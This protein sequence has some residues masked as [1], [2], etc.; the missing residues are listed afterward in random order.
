MPPDKLA[1]ESK[2]PYMTVVNIKLMQ[3]II[4]AIRQIFTKI[5]YLI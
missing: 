5:C 4:K 3:E 2:N 1:T